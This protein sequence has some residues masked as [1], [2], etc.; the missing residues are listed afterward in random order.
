MVDFA[1]MKEAKKFEGDT[2]TV[3]WGHECIQPKQ[4][5]VYNVGPFST[6]TTIRPGETFEEAFNRAYTML[7]KMAEAT[8]LKKRN[9][10]AEHHLNRG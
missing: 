7:E 4:Y 1:K 8:F 9:Q 2:I 10:F 6:T 5:N 3:T